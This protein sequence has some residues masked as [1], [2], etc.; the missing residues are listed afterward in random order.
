LPLQ[1]RQPAKATTST[2][3]VSQLS[4][5]VWQACEEALSL[6]SNPRE[7]LYGNLLDTAQVA[8][9]AGASEPEVRNLLTHLF[10]LN[11]ATFIEA[12]EVVCDVV[13]VP[14]PE[15]FQWPEYP[16]RVRG[17]GGRV[18]SPEL[19][20]FQADFPLSLEGAVAL[21]Q[22]L[23]RCTRDQLACRYGIGVGTITRR[24]SAQVARFWPDHHEV[25]PLAKAVQEW[26]RGR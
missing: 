1:G 25:A 17:D 12:I 13:P 2:V 4:P 8:V 15:K 22:E 20:G 11:Q 23:Q 9:L 5:S 21:G 16:E 19:Y 18:V 14:Q 10:F 7:G 6:G 24:A 26:K 3:P